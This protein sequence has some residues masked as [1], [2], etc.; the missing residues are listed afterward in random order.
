MKELK[1]VLATN[2]AVSTSLDV[3]RVLITTTQKIT[4]AFTHQLPSGGRQLWLRIEFMPWWHGF[5]ALGL[6]RDCGECA[7]DSDVNPHVP[8]SV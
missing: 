8:I 3:E 6:N 7:P 5:A 1:L 2:A 4:E